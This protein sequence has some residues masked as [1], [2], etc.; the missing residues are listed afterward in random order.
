MNL[1]GLEDYVFEHGGVTV[2][3][4]GRGRANKMTKL[5]IEEWPVGCPPDAI[6]A[7]LRERVNARI[8]REYGSV[9]MIFLMQMLASVVIKLIIEWW[10]SDMRNRDQMALIHAEACSNI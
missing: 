1:A 5:V 2:S 9:V 6:A 3:T 8:R 10:F 7:A 4:A